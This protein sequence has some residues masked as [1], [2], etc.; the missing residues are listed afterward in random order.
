[1]PE[2]PQRLEPYILLNGWPK[3]WTEHYTRSNYYADDPVAAWC[4]RPVN[5]FEW[6][7][8]PFDAERSPRAAEVMAV[9]REFG[10][11][12]GFLV[13]IVRSTGLHASVD[14][15]AYLLSLVVL[16]A[17]SLNASELATRPE[18]PPL[19]D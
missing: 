17:E 5:P 10:L 8:A 9:A 13:P 15:L 1:V 3:G 14:L 4:R 2:P 18:D 12:K 6:S 16:E 11:N 7:Q 19:R